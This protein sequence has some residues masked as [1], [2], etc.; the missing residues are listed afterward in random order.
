M[1]QLCVGA[2]IGLVIEDQATMGSLEFHP[3]P[4]HQHFC[5]KGESLEMQ[6]IT[7]YAYVIRP[8]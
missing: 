2:W 7:E 6:L 3:I 8:P 1:Q 4:T 5:T